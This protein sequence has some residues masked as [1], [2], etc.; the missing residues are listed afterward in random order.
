MIA[1][2]RRSTAP[3]SPCGVPARTRRVRRLLFVTLGLAFLAPWPVPP[4]LATNPDSVK[5]T[6]EG[7]RNDGTITLPTSGGK[8]ICPDPPPLG[9]PDSTYTAGNLGKSWNELDLVPYRFIADAGNSA[10]ASQTYTIAVVLD[11]A[12][13]GRTGYD[14]LS[15][16]ELNTVLSDAGC[17]A[18]VVGAEHTVS[19]GLGGI[20][21]SRYR[22]VTVTQAKNTTCVFDYFG[23]LALGSHLFLGASLH[24]NLALPTTDV[25]EIT[26][27][28]IGSK[29]VSIPV[30]QIAPQ[31]LSKDMGATE[32][33]D[34]VW[35]LA[36]S[37]SPAEVKFGDTCAPDA[38]FTRPVAISIE[39]QIL[40]AAPMGD[41]TVVTHIYA[42]NPA[43]RSI[44]VTVTD[45]IRSGTTV[46]DTATGSATVPANT[47]L[48]VL[49]HTTTL[50]SGTTD[51]NDVATATYTDLV[52]GIPVPGQTTAAASATVQFTD[53]DTA[54]VITDQESITGDGLSFSVDTTT[55]G[56]F[57]GGYTLGTPTTGPVDWSSGTQTGG[58][59]VT[60]GKTIRLDGPRITSGTLS[61]GATLTGSSGFTATAAASATVSADAT[62]TLT[63][64]KTMPDILQGS[65]TVTFSFTVTDSQHNVVATPTITFAAGE[66]SKSV[67]VTG[68]APGT[69]TVTETPDPDFTSAADPANGVVTI[70]LPKCSGAVRFDNTLAQQGSAHAQVEKVTIPAGTSTGWSFTLTGPGVSE[71]VNNVQAGTGF[72]PFQSPLTQEGTY[73][74]TETGGPAGFDQTGS[75]GCTFTVNFPADSG[76]TFSCTVTNTQ[77]QGRIIIRKV[78]NPSGSPQS[79]TFNPSYG[80][81]FNLTD[82]QS[83][84][85]GPLVPGIYAVSESVPAG[86]DLTSA[87]CSDGSPV[88]AISLQADE[89]VTCTF[90]NTKASSIDNPP[91]PGGPA[92]TI[93]FWKN[94]ASCARSKGHQTPVLDQTLQLGDI[95]IGILTL[96]DSNPD[97]TVASDC[98]AAVR[99]LSKQRID[100]G[101]NKASDPAFNLAAQ[102]LAADLNVLAGAG[103]CPTAAT[104]ITSAQ[105]LLA[106]IHFNG[107]THDKMTATQV[108]QAHS[109]ATTL[110]KYN[111]NTL[112]Q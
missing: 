60:F 5:F 81:S 23:R 52:S 75:S 45:Q 69:Y 50:P 84:D 65:D 16:P 55:A 68:L 105:S 40:A 48:L 86:W 39:W 78:T 102:L 100:N 21:T 24:A 90:T 104:A 70:N 38:T 91:P 20:G 82:G 106:V 14:V 92:R 30:N 3:A 64:T 25:H 89:T 33:T 95:T 108:S 96:H 94:W 12:D 13:A 76:N 80:S 99:L 85:S 19:P 93:G 109:L 58:G 9:G 29:D 97:P 72:V 34:H 73:A 112:C 22:L 8:F 37:R 111:N 17:T 41:I 32:N 47:T 43:S 35:T 103:T 18:P 107:Q 36:K 63:I 2:G 6:L 61:D 53:L 98:L 10:P 31:E 26:T 101:Q 54:A 79:F 88:T 27:S 49:T 67:D 51:L 7:C 57:A 83:N 74:I 42:T 71:T 66:T 46:F 28:G 59:A 110:D 62:V 44:T 87:T 4:A 56:T 11:A 77:R 1:A 15:A